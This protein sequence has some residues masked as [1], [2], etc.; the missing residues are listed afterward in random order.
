MGETIKHLH[1]YSKDHPRKPAETPRD[2]NKPQR[3]RPMESAMDFKYLGEFKAA[4]LFGV[5]DYW[6]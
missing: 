3:D 5:C 2:S 1:S 6:D 4:V